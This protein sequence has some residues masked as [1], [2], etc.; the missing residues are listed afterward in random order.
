MAFVAAALSLAGGIAGTVMLARA[1][2]AAVQRVLDERLWG[3]GES[4]A[5][6]VGDGALSDAQLSALAHSNHLDGAWLLDDSLTVRAS[7][8]GS[9]GKPADLLRLDPAQVASALKGHP[10]VGAGARVGS[11]VLRTGYFHVGASGQVLVLEGGEA[12]KEAHARIQRAQRLSLL[13][14]LLDALALAALG[15][16]WAR[17]AA[18]RQQMAERAARGEALARVAAT[19]AHEIRNPLGIIRGTI[20]LLR[21]RS[22]AHLTERDQRGLS[23]VLEEVDRMRA[24]TDDLLDLSADRPLA[25]A[26]VDLAQILSDAARAAEATHADLRIR[27]EL[28]EALPVRGDPG[29]LRQVFANLLQNAAQAQRSGEI[30][31]TASAGGDELRVR[32]IDQGP[33]V[34]AEVR[35]RLFEPFVTSR[36]QGTGLGLAVARRL[37]V[38]HGGALELVPTERGATFEVRMPVRR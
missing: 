6:L 36:A 25:E 14:V 38:R 16:A 2:N 37:I 21:E 8:D 4:A 31:V 30:Q 1:A 23:D 26:E 19:A 15:A 22:V 29:R 11:T 5:L 13:V 34:P 35:S 32:V 3:A 20:E 9:T 10:S 28:P 18:R 7:T 33:G 27:L 24:L 12:F 17:Q